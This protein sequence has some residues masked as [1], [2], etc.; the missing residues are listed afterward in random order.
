MRT[1]IGAALIALSVVYVIAGLVLGW[2]SIA[3]GA[4]ALIVAGS[5]MLARG[6]RPPRRKA[7]DD[8][9]FPKSPRVP[10]IP[11]SVRPPGQPAP[12]KRTEGGW[13]EG[14]VILPP[15]PETPPGGTPK[16]TLVHS[17]GGPVDVRDYRRRAA[18]NK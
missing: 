10:S 18:G 11:P 6:M 13:H 2:G 1:A 17:D 15:P 9:A 5:I 3:L 7:P 8:S 12:E 16:L 4:T 14:D